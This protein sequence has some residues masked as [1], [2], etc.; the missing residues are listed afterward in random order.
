[1]KIET[2]TY[3]NFSTILFWIT[4]IGIMAGLFFTFLSWIGACTSACAEGHNY[5]MFGYPFEWFGFAYFISLLL[6]YLFSRHNRVFSFLT[7]LLLAA[8]IGSEVMFILIQKYTIGSWCPVCLCIAGSVGIAAAA[9]AYSFVKNFQMSIQEGKRSDIMLNLK[10][11]L[12]NFSVLIL[13]FTTAFI[14][15]A[16]HDDLQ[17]AEG[18]FQH[19]IVFGDEKSPIE[20]YVFTSWVCPAC[21]HFEPTLEK[22]APELMKEAKV[23]FVDYGVDDTTLNYLPYNLS[24]MLHQKEKYIPLRKAIKEMAKTTEEP[25]DEG[26]EKAAEALGVKYKQINYADVAAGIEL[27][28]DLATDLKVKSLPSFVIIDT[29][30]KKIVHLSGLNELTLSNVEKSIKAL[31]GK[32]IAEK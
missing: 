28:K 24:F 27:F 6:S 32:V 29:K 10:K 19:R 1:M 23:V 14:G 26:V 25:D 18:T 8:G 5:R 3:S 16:K 22:M 30:T 15:V 21:R 4:G 12:C 20:I 7:G 11:A 31:N 2:H 9:W 13:G 17:A